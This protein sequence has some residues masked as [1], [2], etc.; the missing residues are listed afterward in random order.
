[1]RHFLTTLDW[2]R[3]ELQGLLDSAAELRRE[4]VNHRL[5]GKAVAL[6]FLN[7][8]LRTR[9]SFEIGAFQLGA[10]AVVLEPGKAAWGIEFEPGVVMDGDAEEH[11]TEVAGVLSRYCDAIGLRAFPLFKDWSVDRQDRVIKALAE[12]ASV[13]VINM[14]TIVHPC[15]ELALM[16]T[17]QDHLG[18]P[19]GRKFVLTW[20]W[21]P[22]PL[23][24][25]VANSALLIASKFGMDITLL[26]PE[27]AY[28]LDEQFM[29]AGQRQ[30]ETAGGS[31][32]VTSD[33]EEAYTGAE[34]VY[35]KSWGALPFYGRPDEE[36]SLR[37]SF[38]HFMV[39]GA[40]MALTNGARFSHCLPLRRN[41]KASDEVMDADYCVALDEAEN[42]LHVQKAL[43]LKLMDEA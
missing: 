35:A 12:H 42:R 33:I 37:A 4:P 5:A 2:S 30:A 10:H 16:R 28:L 25:A 36:S 27:P 41:I 14:E 8:S 1:M 19:D 9:S 21:H 23:N 20:T 34:F 43:M 22:R 40:K 11:I 6:L 39:D 38:R 24:T 26:I 13:P 15:Q 32:R 18:Q 29:D 3:E 7:P 31:L 17:L